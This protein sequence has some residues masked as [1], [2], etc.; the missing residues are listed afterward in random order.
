MNK[1]IQSWIVP[2]SIAIILVVIMVML[3]V[4]III[5][6]GVPEKICRS[7][8]GVSMEWD[9]GSRDNLGGYNGYTCVL[10]NGT[11]F[12]ILLELNSLA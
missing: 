3:A 6:A 5:E 9:E 7:A 2:I 4:Q 8:N 1:E 12:P 10:E 11:K